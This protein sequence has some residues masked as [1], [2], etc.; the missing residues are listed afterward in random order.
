MQKVENIDENLKKETNKRYF[1]VSFFGLNN[2]GNVTGFID[3]ST[4]G[5]F[6]SCKKTVEQIKKTRK[7]KKCVITNIIELTEQDWNDWSN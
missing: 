1:I 7:L 4:D 6:L 2:L 5:G 3:F